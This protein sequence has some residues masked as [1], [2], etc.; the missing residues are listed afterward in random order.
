MVRSSI[1]YVSERIGVAISA[2][3]YYEERGFFGLSEQREVSGGIDGKSSVASLSLELLE[4]VGLSLEEIREALEA[5]LNDRTLTKA[6]WARLSSACR[7]Q[8]DDSIGVADAITRQPH[9]LHRMWS[10]LAES[11]LSRS[12]RGDMAAF[13]RALLAIF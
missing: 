6:D 1:G 13:L 7:S 2:L 4:Q 11:A 12:T 10:P 5:L 8:L 9:F 3:R